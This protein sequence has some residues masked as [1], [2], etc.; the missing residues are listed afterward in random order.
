[1]ATVSDLGRLVKQKY[2]GAYD[3][4]PDA[5]LGVRVQQKHPGSYD[6]FT[7]EGT[8]STASAQ[9]RVGDRVVDARILLLH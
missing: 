7:A 4:I 1:M 6:S 5:D 2:P 9:V 8:A 3:S